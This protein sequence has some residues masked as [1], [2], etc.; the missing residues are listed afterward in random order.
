M[1]VRSVLL[2]LVVS[3]SINN[4]TQE[5]NHS[6]VMSVRCVLLDLVVSTCINDYTQERNHPNLISVR[7]VF[8]RM[9]HL[10]EH[11]RLHTGEK[12]HHCDVCQMCLGHAS[13]LT[14]HNRLHK[15]QKPL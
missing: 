12:P 11:K 5:R 15:G 8:T 6:N 7:S 3:T 2:D 9:S 14:R 4:Y 1:P 13:A 10:K